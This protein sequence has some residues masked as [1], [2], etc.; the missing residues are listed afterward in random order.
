MDKWK[1]RPLEPNVDDWPWLVLKNFTSERTHFSN[2]PWRPTVQGPTPLSLLSGE[3]LYKKATPS[4]DLNPKH[5]SVI[6]V[7]IPRHFLQ[8]GLIPVKLRCTLKLQFPNVFLAIN[9]M[10]TSGKIL[11]AQD[12]L[13]PKIWPKSPKTFL[14]SRDSNR[15][16]V[17][18]KHWTTNK[19]KPDHIN[20]SIT[21]SKRHR[22]R[23]DSSWMACGKD[24]AQPQVSPQEV[25]AK[26]L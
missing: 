21:D 18:E 19:L 7:L 22:D 5:L 15:F 16:W 3:A 12:V 26:N 13:V 4:M 24:G 8:P 9:G 17:S 6:D 2:T 11:C 14:C 25:R 20:I 10:L 23:Q 1:H